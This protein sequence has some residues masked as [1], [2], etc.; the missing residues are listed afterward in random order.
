M[1]LLLL[2]EPLELDDEVEADALPPGPFWMSVWM[3]AKAVFAEV[4][5]PELSALAKD[6]KSCPSWPPGRLL[7][8]VAVVYAAL[9]EDILSMLMECLFAGVEYGAGESS[10]RSP[11]ATGRGLSPTRVSGWIA[12]SGKQFAGQFDFPAQRVPCRRGLGNTS[13]SP[14]EILAAVADRQPTRSMEQV[15]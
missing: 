12:R 4:R 15:C 3:L 1:G 14:M 5:S 8:F 11:E 7:L 13:P 9:F 2:E 10:L 6:W